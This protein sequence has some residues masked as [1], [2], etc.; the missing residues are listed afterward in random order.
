MNNNFK[1]IT[2][3]CIVGF[4][5]SFTDAYTL[6][7]YVTVLPIQYL[8][9]KYAIR[10]KNFPILIMEAIWLLSIG[11]GSITFFLNRS[12]AQSVGFRAIGN[13]KFSYGDFFSVYSFFLLFQLLVFI[14][15]KLMQSQSNRF[16]II[17]FVKEEMNNITESKSHSSIFPLFV[18]IVT[19]SIISISMYYNHIGM[20]GLQQTRLPF[21][22][23]GILFYS[24]KFLFTAILIY[25]FLRTENKRLGAI[26]LILYAFLVSVTGSSKS[27]NIMILAPVAF[28][29]FIHGYKKTMW[30][31]L[32]SL[33]IVYSFV[34]DARTLIYNTDASLPVVE[35]ISNSFSIFSDN[36]NI[37]DFVFSFVDGFCER[38]YGMQTAVLT[39]Q[40]TKLDFDDF[41]NFYTLSATGSD[42]VPDFSRTLFG[43]VLPD[44]MAFGVG[45]GYT[46]TFTML[47][48]NNYIIAI[49]Q[50]LIVAVNFG[51][52]NRFYQKT[53]KSSRRLLKYAA[54]GLIL[55]GLM[56][57]NDGYSIFPLYFSTLSLFFICKYSKSKIR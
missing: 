8:F 47:T 30:L 25:L 11:I 57:F 39:S 56:G 31:V 21:H 45:V 14:I 44:D 4:I 53:M 40:Y 12:E 7:I 19:F 24:R 16:S 22:L 15:L 49:L 5:I 1:L 18:S 42:L 51:L 27:L 41:L 28:L 36:F 32:A 50:A 26:L 2:I 13:F 9:F 20:T 34:S 23:T 17:D 52:Q 55:F 48:N 37:R 3:Y 10:L 38:L 46:G 43:I 6:P 33:V 35:L 54:L 29:C